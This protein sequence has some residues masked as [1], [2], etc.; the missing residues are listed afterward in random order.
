MGLANNDHLRQVA[1]DS[2]DK[3]GFG[4][5]SVRFICGTMDI[6]QEFERKMADFLGYEDVISYSSCFAANNGLFQALFDKEDAI[7]TADLNHASL[8]DGIRLCKAARFFYEFDNMSDLEEK[9][10]AA[11]ESGS[12]IELLSQ[13]A[14]FQWMVILLN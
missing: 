7:I 6:H 5:A 10:K 13:M 14:Y 12:K 4:T 2:I 8:I 3:Y 1:K 11:V 9:I